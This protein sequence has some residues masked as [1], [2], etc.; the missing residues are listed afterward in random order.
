MDLRTRSC[1]TATSW[2]SSTGTLNRK[3]SCWAPRTTT[4]ASRR[5]CAHVCCPLREEGEA[6]QRAISI[7]IEKTPNKKLL[8]GVGFWAVG[9]LQ[10]WPG[11]DRARGL[12]FLRRAR[13]EAAR[14]LASLEL[15]L[16][17]GAFLF[18]FLPVCNTFISVQSALFD[19]YSST[20]LSTNKPA[21]LSTHF[22]AF[23]TAK[24][25]ANDS[26]LDSTFR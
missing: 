17:F 5:A 25:P 6:V 19:S 23:I 24:V 3:T 9:V 14:T 21:V 4:G 2:A 15:V 11:L 26:T 7:K 8:S 1:F 16:Q 20:V 13:G 18:S 10:A 12:P 22:A